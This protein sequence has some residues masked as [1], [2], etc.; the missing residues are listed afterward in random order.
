MAATKAQRVGIVISV[1]WLLGWFVAAGLDFGEEGFW[2][3]G[4]VPVLIAWSIWW[5]RRAKS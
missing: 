1:L 3:A 4:V 2:I 5:V